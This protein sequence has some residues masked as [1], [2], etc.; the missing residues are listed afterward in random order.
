M[1]PLRIAV[2]ALFAFVL[3][4]ALLRFSGKRFVAEATGFDFVLA[5]VLGDIVDDLLWAEVGA[6]QFTVAAGTLVLARLAAAAAAFHSERAA[7]LLGGAPRL[8]L[9]DG[10]PLR[11]AL[12]RERMNLHELAEGLRVA[13]LETD[14]WPEIRS[15]RLE[16]RGRLSVLRKPWAEQ[17]RR[18]D[19]DA[20]RKAARSNPS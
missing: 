18:V 3:L 1:D 5:L 17:A 16:K 7:G 11:P 9:R 2:R 4:H 20:A 13:G 12:R 6:A 19:A 15:A 8:V 14:E 10:A